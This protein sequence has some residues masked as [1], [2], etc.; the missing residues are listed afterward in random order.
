MDGVHELSRKWKSLPRVY[1]NPITR[2]HSPAG[3]TV[4]CAPTAR[5]SESSVIR[6][7]ID[8]TGVGTNAA[9]SR[10]NFRYARDHRRSSERRRT[11][12]LGL[13]LLAF[14]RAYFMRDA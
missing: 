3:D 14:M 6:T 5:V 10:F 12:P 8:I 13:E 1:S 2:V 11:P 7:R 4:Q 9:V